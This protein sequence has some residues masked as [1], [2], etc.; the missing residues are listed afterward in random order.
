MILCR[1]QDQLLGKALSLGSSVVVWLSPALTPKTKLS[2]Y[3]T[4][5]MVPTVRKREH[6]LM[7]KFLTG[8]T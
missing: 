7:V 4:G 5:P 3:Q 6:R 1:E 2:V 8:R